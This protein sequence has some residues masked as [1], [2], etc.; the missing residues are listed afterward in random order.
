MTDTAACEATPIARFVR[1][2]PNTPSL[3]AGTAFPRPLSGIGK[4]AAP[5]LI[6]F[7]KQ[8]GSEFESVQPRSSVIARATTRPRYDL[9]AVY[10]NIGSQ[11]T[12][13]SLVPVVYSYHYGSNFYEIQT[14]EDRALAGR[15]HTLLSEWKTARDPFASDMSNMMLPAYQQIVGMGP[16]AIPLIMSELEKNLDEWF[17]ALRAI[18]GADPVPDEHLGDLEAMRG[19]W[20][21]WAQAN[22]YQW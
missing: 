8:F 3:Y 14:V 4:T 18:T 6:G 21:Q 15:F 22:G 2:Q 12:S 7:G 13:L 19:D 5:I 9:G 17:W 10:V 20:M 11:G 16:A 1:P